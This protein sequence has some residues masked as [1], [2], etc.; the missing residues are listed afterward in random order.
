[1]EWEE[2]GQEREQKEEEKKKRTKMRR[3]NVEGE[4]GG[5]R[6]GRLREEKRMRWTVEIKTTREHVRRRRRTGTRPTGKLIMRGREAKK[7]RGR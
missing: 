3:R 5:G 7:G 4:K 6:G 2:E 1:M